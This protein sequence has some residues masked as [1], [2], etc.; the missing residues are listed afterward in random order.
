MAAVM[1]TG[2]IEKFE[3]AVKIMQKATADVDYPPEKALAAAH[4]DSEQFA[5]G[6]DCLLA[7]RQSAVQAGNYD[8]ARRVTG[9]MFHTLQDFYSHTNWN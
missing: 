1:I 2:Y 7:L 6:Q 3:H 8:G 9:R 5:S 4:F